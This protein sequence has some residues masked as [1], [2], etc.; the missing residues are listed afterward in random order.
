MLSKNS[1]MCSYVLALSYVTSMCYRNF[2]SCLANS[3]L[4]LPLC[5]GS[6]WQWE[7]MKNTAV[8]HHHHP[9]PWHHTDN[10]AAVTPL[11]AAPLFHHRQSGFV[12]RPW[13]RWVCQLHCNYSDTTE[14]C[15]AALWPVCDPVWPVC[16]PVWPL[17][18]RT[19]C[20]DW[21]DDGTQFVNIIRIS[22]EP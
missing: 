6:Q 11:S 3:K 5:F 1:Q 16:D 19:L 21:N 2:K 20:P 13:W 4:Y 17:L 15:D 14:W 18:L 12:L 9:A 7:V 22:Y 8:L 10:G